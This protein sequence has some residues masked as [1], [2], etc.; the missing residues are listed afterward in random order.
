MNNIGLK[1]FRSITRISDSALV[2]LLE[3]G[4]LPIQLASDGRL[5]VDMERVDMKRLVN[6]L[7]QEL[8][9][10]SNEEYNLMV[11]E[12]GRIIRNE[13]ESLIEVAISRS[14]E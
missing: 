6:V 8:A 13:M 2:W 9:H 7:N 4:A 3:R 14:K 11:E 12:A 5:T 10:T 1:E